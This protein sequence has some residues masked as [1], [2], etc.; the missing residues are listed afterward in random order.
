MSNSEPINK[1]LT[2]IKKTEFFSPQNT[3]LN[4]DTSK[5]VK[6]IGDSLLK[7]FSN[8]LPL[9]KPVVQ[10]IGNSVVEPFGK[11]IANLFSSSFDA[12]IDSS[13]FN[14]SDFIVRPFGK[15]VSDL[16]SSSFD[17][18]I[19]GSVFNISDSVIRPFGK[20]VS[21]LFSS[22]FDAH[23]DGSVINISDSVVRPFGKSIADLFSTSFNEPINESFSKSFGDSFVKILKKNVVN[24]NDSLFNVR[25]I[26][27]SLFIN[28]LISSFSN[29]Q[30]TENYVDFPD[31][32]A[33]IIEQS[34]EADEPIYQ[35]GVPSTRFKRMSTEKFITY[36]KYIIPIITFILTVCGFVNDVSSSI[37][38]EK[39]HEELMSEE[40]KQ[41]KELEKS[42][43]LKLDSNKLQQESNEIQRERLKLEKE[44]L[45]DKYK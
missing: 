19:D 14:I 9:N 24:T 43:K 36:C 17:A 15:S 12:H 26:E 5:F 31:P 3:T 4:I 23:M 6:P 10:I 22:S 42:N 35:N 30:V 41:T 44:I 18:H 39:H 20:S 38:E 16:F 40:R 28:N 33:S 11:S 8:S 7:S 1:H 27:N 21:V 32:L 34:L 2:D 25:D 45:K 29:I 37:T 13:V